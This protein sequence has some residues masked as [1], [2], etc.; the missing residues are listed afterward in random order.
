MQGIDGL[1]ETVVAVGEHQLAA[2]DIGY[3]SIGK[4]EA[5]FHDLPAGPVIRRER[6]C[7]LA[8]H[9]GNRIRRRDRFDPIAVVLKQKKMAVKGTRQS[10]RQ[11][12]ISVA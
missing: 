5:V 3:D 1:P 9:A 4:G 6:R 8:H 7:H 2:G 11:M 10:G 12:S